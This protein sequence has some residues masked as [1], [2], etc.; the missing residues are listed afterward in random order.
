MKYN[1]MSAPVAVAFAATNPELTKTFLGQLKH[2]SKQISIGLVFAII[3]VIIIVICA[4]MFMRRKR[5]TGS[6]KEGYMRQEGYMRSEGYM[7]SN[8]GE[9]V[10]QYFGM[11]KA[12]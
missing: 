11:L 12:K 9:R 6:P 8:I 5:G 7:P 3:A 1:I 4:I 10:N 2:H